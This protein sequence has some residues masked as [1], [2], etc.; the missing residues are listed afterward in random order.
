MIVV[1]KTQFTVTTGTIHKYRQ[2]VTPRFGHLVKKLH[3]FC[4]KCRVITALTEQ[5]RWIIA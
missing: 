2:L 1:T 3:C 5:H 4:A